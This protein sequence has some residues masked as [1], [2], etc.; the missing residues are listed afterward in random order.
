MFAISQGKCGG[1]SWFFACIW[2]SKVSSNWYYHFRCV[3]PGTPKLPKITSF[4]FPYN[5]LGKKWA[6]KLI[7]CTQMSKKVSYKLIQW[8]LMG[9]AIFSQNRK[10]VIT[11]QYLKKEVR[12][13]VDFLCADK[14][15]SFL[16]VD[17]STL[18]NKVSYKVVLS[19][20]MGM[21]RQVTSLQCLYN[22]SKRKLTTKLFNENMIN[23]IF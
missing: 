9:M 10:F 18:G 20:L 2:S 23:K 8:F 22:I 3:L 5:I 16:E 7:F 21:I 15:Q 14:H 17:F 12:D 19:L 4:L 6:M 11:L 13:E 1:W